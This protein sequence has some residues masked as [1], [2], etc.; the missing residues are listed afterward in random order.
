MSIWSSHNLHNFSFPML[1][2]TRPGGMPSL[3]LHPYT[4]YTH[5][6]HPPRMKYCNTQCE[7]DKWD[8]FHLVGSQY[9]FAELTLHSWFL[10]SKRG[11]R[12]HTSAALKKAKSKYYQT[13][14][15]NSA[16]SQSSSCF[17]YLQLCLLITGGHPRRNGCETVTESKKYRSLSYLQMEGGMGLSEQKQ[18]K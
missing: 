9:E 2:L 12:S 1:L 8:Q 6:E 10:Q 16:L 3:N 17:P 4:P 7:G 13:V 11:H 14:D 18:Q 15:L 5:T